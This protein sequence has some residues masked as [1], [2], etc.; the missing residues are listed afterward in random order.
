MLGGR[1]EADGNNTS[2]QGVSARSEEKKISGL[3]LIDSKAAGTEQGLLFG[4][5]QGWRTW[6]RGCSKRRKDEG[7]GR[8]KD[9]RRVQ[10][11]GCCEGAL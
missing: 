11:P 10:R 2:W 7:A 6:E 9:I 8:E 5:R 1:I 4:R 3:D